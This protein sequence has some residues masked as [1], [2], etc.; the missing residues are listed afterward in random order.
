MGDGCDRDEII[1]LVRE[2]IDHAITSSDHDFTIE[3]I[4]ILEDI[5]EGLEEVL[6]DISDKMDK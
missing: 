5:S 2:A 4:E 6:D 1:E 3:E